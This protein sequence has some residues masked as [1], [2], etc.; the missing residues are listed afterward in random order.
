L[1][2]RRAF[3]FFLP[4]DRNAIAM[5]CFCGWPF[6]IS[7]PMLAETVFSELPFKSGMIYPL[8]GGR[9]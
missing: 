2:V 1:V 3:Y 7:R 9:P 5:A 4:A 8:D 6:L